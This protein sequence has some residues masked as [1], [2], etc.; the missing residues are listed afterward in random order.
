MR[1]SRL[2]RP[3][4][5]AVIVGAGAVAISLV[6]T[7]AGAAVISGD[8]PTTLSSALVGTATSTGAS[9]AVDYDCLIDDSTTA[10]DEAKC[11]TGVGDSP[12]AGFPTDGSTFAIMASGNAALADDANTETGS[13][14]GWGFA[15]TAIGPEVF[16]HQV[17][18]IDLGAASGNCLTFDFR[19][20]SEE[21]PEYVTSGFNDA[22]VAQLNTWS[23][24]ADPATQTLNAPGNFAAG[25]GDIISVDGTGPSAM[26]AELASG[27]T[28]DGATL[29]LIAR[30]PVVSGSTNTL[31]LTIFDQGDAILDSAVFVDNLRYETLAPGQCK[32]LA[33]DPFEGT[34]GV[35]VTPGGSGAF[36][37]TLSTFT[38]PLTSNLPSGPIDTNITATATFLNW[39]DAVPRHQALAA[40]KATTS[41][42]S[43]TAKIPAGGTGNLVLTSS[44]QGIAAVQAAKAQPALLLAQAKVAT[45]KAKKLIAKAKKLKKQAK[46]APPLKA[47]KL[48]KKA[49]KLIKKAKKLIRKAK[50]LRA[51]SKVLAAQ[52]L[53]T[54]VVT[55]TN[56]SNGKSELLRLPVPR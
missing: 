31:Y 30:A 54:V 45:K 23:V 56:A 37:P 29:R 4:S 38:V 25:A 17:V 1:S 11:P 15:A 10:E 20:L 6:W 41:L 39:G 47:A 21:F 43:G 8:D 19:F 13:G 28:Y 18:R 26:T 42:G 34:T 16:D 7:S 49:K 32:S 3:R 33:V 51:Q 50:A 9:L 46:T 24:T 5:R 22:L 55:V 27:T 48:I 35:V 12:M 44:P 53:G 14:E 2:A 36:S 52:P 40:R